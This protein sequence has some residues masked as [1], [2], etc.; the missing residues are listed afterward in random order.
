MRTVQARTDGGGGFTRQPYAMSTRLTF[1]A[2]FL[3]LL[4]LMPLPLVA[5]GLEGKIM[6]GYQGWFRTPNDGTDT[7]W[8]HYGAR[9]TFAPGA[10][11]ID[12]W[13]D[14]REI[15]AEDR[16]PT[17]F[18]HPNGSSAEVYS[19]VKPSAIQL[20]FRWM[21]EHG[22]DGIFLQRFAVTTKDPKY[23]RPLDAILES[24][25]KAARDN[26][27]VWALMYDLSGLKPGEMH[28]LIADWKRLGTAYKLRDALE[29]PAYLRH[30]GR[31]LVALWG[32]GFSDRA[33]M[34]DEWRELVT[35]LKSDPV[36]G[37]CSIMLGVPCFWR[38]LDRDAIPD[39]ALH[40]VM[41]LADVISPWAVTRYH[42]PKTAQSY[43]EKTVSGD[44]TWCRERQ[45]DFL[46]VAFP[47][48]SWHN[49]QKSRGKEAL[50]N[51]I[52]RL[53]GE[54][55][56]SQFLQS[57]RAGIKSQYVAM[58][59]ELDEGTA[60][61]KVRQDPPSSPDNPFVAEPGVPEDHYLWLTGQGGRLL[62]GELP[63]E[64]DAMPVR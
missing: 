23:R 52:P 7:G 45:L 53:K 60:I 51:A 26:G 61:F 36:H 5:E 11:G 63:A 55:L 46:P 18:V 47:G 31:P 38:T 32:L 29:N 6:C 22:I 37:G 24:C 9:G 27:R 39:P 50:L 1:L 34:L 33:P 56:W 13:P 43:F 14:V 15:P 57:R 40:E 44:L 21:K 48:F 64:S 35:F 25:R 16:T 28:H 62:R 3:V 12:L 17:P 30:R 2:P 54:F 59:D 42:S 10:C 49:L 8:H 4:A 20:H 41:A 19:S 58:F